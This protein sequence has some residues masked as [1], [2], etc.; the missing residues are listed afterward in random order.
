MEHKKYIPTELLLRVGGIWSGSGFGWGGEQ[1]PAAADQ[2]LPPQHQ[3][4]YNEQWTPGEEHLANST[5]FWRKCLKSTAS[6]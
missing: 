5:N 2:P 4:N 1:V 6:L 3:E